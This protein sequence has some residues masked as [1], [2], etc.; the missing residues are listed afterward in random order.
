MNSFEDQSDHYSSRNLASQSVSRDDSYRG[1]V[2]R[3]TTLIVDDVQR[4][5]VGEFFREVRATPSEHPVT[6][7]A[8]FSGVP[9]NGDARGRHAA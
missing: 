2:A 1:G 9:V 6:R 5:R 4:N 7:T 8:S 3:A